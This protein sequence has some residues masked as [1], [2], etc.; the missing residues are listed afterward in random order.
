[1]VPL[2]ARA[3]ERSVLASARMGGVGLDGLERCFIGP[4]TM[5]GLTLGYAAPTERRRLSDALDALVGWLGPARTPL[6]R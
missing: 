3:A 6:V 2:P 5:F 4:P 1:V